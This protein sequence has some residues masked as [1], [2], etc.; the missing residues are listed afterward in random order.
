MLLSLAK[1]LKLTN[2]TRLGKTSM[3]RV[4]TGMNTGL[5][6]LRTNGSNNPKDWEVNRSRQ[7]LDQ[8]NKILANQTTLKLD[9]SA[10]ADSI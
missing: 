10:I 5:A 9:L 7:G 6:G 2:I 8:D 1:N 4:L 3:N